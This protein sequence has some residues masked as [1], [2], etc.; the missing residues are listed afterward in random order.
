LNREMHTTDLSHC[1]FVFVRVADF[2][3]VVWLAVA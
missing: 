1:V 3:F 2:Y